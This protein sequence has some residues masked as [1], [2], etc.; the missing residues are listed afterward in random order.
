MPPRRTLSER[1][2]SFLHDAL[3]QEE[4][5][6]K[7]KD[8]ARV[9][10]LEVAHDRDTAAT[11]VLDNARVVALEVG[12]ARHDEQIKDHDTV[13]SELKQHLA[14]LVARFDSIER[15]ALVVVVAFF[16]SSGQADNVMKYLGL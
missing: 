11:T 1:I 13:L 7:V 12:H 15:K 14:D 10:A 9:V 4:A 5:G 8:T 3:A 2:A 16:V 6:T